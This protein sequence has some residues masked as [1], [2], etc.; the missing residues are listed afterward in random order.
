MGTAWARACG[1]QSHHWASS[2]SWVS[3]LS[4]LFFKNRAGLPPTTV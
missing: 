3:W 2:K 1:S 4:N